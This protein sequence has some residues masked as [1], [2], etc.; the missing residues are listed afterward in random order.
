MKKT[1]VFYPNAELRRNTTSYNGERVLKTIP[2]FDQDKLPGDRG[3]SLRLSHGTQVEYVGTW[4]E[5]ITGPVSVVQ[6]KDGREV[7]VNGA[8]IYLPARGMFVSEYEDE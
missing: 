6:L 1:R 2:A 7:R 8:N 5:S 4:D 3:Y